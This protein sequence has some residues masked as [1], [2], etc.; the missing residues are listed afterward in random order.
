[1]S[2]IPGLLSYT[3]KFNA[4][5]FS[6]FGHFAGRESVPGWDNNSQPVPG[7]SGWQSSQTVT[8]PTYD[9]STGAVV[10]SQTM[11]LMQRVPHSARFSPFMSWIFRPDYVR[12]SFRR[13]VWA[14][15][16]GAPTPD[17]CGGAPSCRTAGVGGGV[18]AFG[19]PSLNPQVTVEGGVIDA[20]SVLQITPDTWDGQD[21]DSPLNASVWP[22]LG[23]PAHSRDPVPGVPFFTV[24]YG[25]V[26]AGSVSHAID[27]TFT[28]YWKGGGG[29]M[30]VL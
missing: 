8:C 11:L 26:C 30:C 14:A 20:G 17:G 1:M 3:E 22:V 19:G 7:Q 23:N 28:Y 27:W 9:T 21:P 2:D 16:G 24:D 6:G 25:S 4:T 29:W 18:N 5:D 13:G 15:S 10:G 12:I